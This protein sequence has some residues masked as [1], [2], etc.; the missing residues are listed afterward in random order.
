MDC[1]SG[2]G[3]GQLIGTW[4]IVTYYSPLMAIILFYMA[5]SFRSV[6]PWTYCDPSWADHHCV[7][8]SSNVSFSNDSQSSAEQFFVLVFFP[9]Y[10]HQ[11]QE[12][13]VGCPMVIPEA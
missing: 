8:A 13:F 12:S 5:Q 2:I 6:L 3:Y 11:G 1:P 7:D 9:L 10:S 4:S